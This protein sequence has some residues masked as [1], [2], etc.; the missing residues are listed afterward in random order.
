MYLLN[1]SLIRCSLKC[2]WHVTRILKLHCYHFLSSSLVGPIFLILVCPSNPWRFN[3]AEFYSLILLDI[4]FRENSNFTQATKNH[5]GHFS[6]AK[7]R[8]V[9]IILVIIFVLFI[10]LKKC[11][12]LLSKTLY[13][14]SSF[15][16]L[17]PKGQTQTKYKPRYNF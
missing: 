3:R 1:Y 7:S 14:S 8:W 17:E 9:I 11:K 16:N 10:L 4:S 15:Y 6:L 12:V 13:I 5:T 2:Y